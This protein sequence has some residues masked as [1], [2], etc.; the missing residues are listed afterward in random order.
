MQRTCMHLAHQPESQK[1]DCLYSKLASG[2]SE[3]LLNV[4]PVLMHDHK[5]IFL[6]R[7]GVFSSRHKLRHREVSQLMRLAPTRN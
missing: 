5:P 6:L 3:L 1:T 2:S 4:F 7:V